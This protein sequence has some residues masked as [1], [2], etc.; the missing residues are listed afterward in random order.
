MSRESLLPR[1]E[2]L[3]T[4]RLKKVSGR[5]ESYC[6]GHVCRACLELQ[7]AFGKTSWC[8]LHLHVMSHIAARLTRRHVVRES[9]GAPTTHRF[10]CHPSSCAQ[11]TPDPAAEKGNKLR[12]FAAETESVPVRSFKKKGA[13]LLEE[14]REPGQIDLSIVDFRLGKI[15][16]DG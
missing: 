1:P 5:S 8:G 13:L 9:P 7:G 16:V 4:K 3:L 6:A 14:Q 2:C 10:P 11:K 12:R 15:D